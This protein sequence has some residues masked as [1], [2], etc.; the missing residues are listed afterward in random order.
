[1]HLGDITPIHK[2]TV[3]ASNERSLHLERQEKRILGLYSAADCISVSLLKF[4]DASPQTRAKKWP[5]CSSDIKLSPF[6]HLFLACRINCLDTKSIVIIHPTVYDGGDQDQDCDGVTDERC[7]NFILTDILR[8]LRVA[9]GASRILLTQSRR[10][11]G[12]A[13]WEC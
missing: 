1:M 12:R 10:C 6:P 3:R 2:C 4:I 11:H 9:A 13:R 5:V 7:S 8:V